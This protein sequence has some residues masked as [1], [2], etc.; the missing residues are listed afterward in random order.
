MYEQNEGKRKKVVERGG[1]AKRKGTE[2]V[3]NT[4]THTHKH[5]AALVPPC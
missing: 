3:R 2:E 1:K 5:A 4:C